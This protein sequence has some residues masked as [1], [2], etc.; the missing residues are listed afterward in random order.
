M[1]VYLCF[2]FFF[3][4]FSSVNA[5]C[6][7]CVQAKATFFRNSEA[8]SYGACGYGPIAL[9]LNAGHVAAALP[10]IYKDGEGCGSCFQIRC[11]KTGVCK[12][13]G[14]TFVVTDS[15]TDDQNITTDFVLSNRAFR[16]MALPGMDK[17]LLHL[18]IADVEYKRVPCVYK[19]QNLAIRVEEFS[20]PPNYL[21]IKVLYQGGQTS[22]LGGDVARDDESVWA[23]LSRKY[24]AVWDTDSAPTG[25][26]TFRFIINSGF[27][28]RYFYTNQGVLPANWKAGVIYNS[29]VQ[30]TDV[31]L[32]VCGRNC[33]PWK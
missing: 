19:H 21:A 9:N 15:Q 4:L 25:N 28:P 26:L 18:G 16:A 32:D 20:K 3:L 10:S 17:Q 14:T 12:G 8:L 31:A 5:A 6:N 27:N 7:Q 23:F 24:G 13:T 1:A 22:I 11:N 2:L 33:K 29:T 30:I